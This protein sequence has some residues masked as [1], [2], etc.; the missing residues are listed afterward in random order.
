MKS[1]RWWMAVL[2][3]ATLPVTV[4][5]LIENTGGHFTEWMYYGTYR[6]IQSLVFLL[7]AGLIAWLMTRPSGYLGLRFT[8]AFLTI[9]GCLLA[10]LAPRPTCEEKVVLRALGAK[11]PAPVASPTGCD[12]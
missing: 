2:F 3:A 8:V 12:A 5:W 11:K 7:T 6:D 10:A 1:L 4:S 9:I